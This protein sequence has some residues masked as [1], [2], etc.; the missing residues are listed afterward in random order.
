LTWINACALELIDEAAMTHLKRSIIT[1]VLIKTSIVL[2]AAL[3]VFGPNQRP[4]VDRN[5]L[6]HQILND[7]DR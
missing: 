6:I 4:K 7:S 3:F 5:A 1:I 2:L